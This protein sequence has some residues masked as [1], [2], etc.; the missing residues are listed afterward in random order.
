MDSGALDQL[1]VK[2]IRFLS[3][4]AVQKANS[5]H[6]GYG[7][8]APGAEVLVRFGFTAENV[9]STA[10]SVLERLR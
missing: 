6:P 3:T 4:D 5:G 2:A 8:S 10:L 9:Q 7:A 1:C